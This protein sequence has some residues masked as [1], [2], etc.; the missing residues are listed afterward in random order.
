MTNP[1]A[2]S[3]EKH[4][5]QPNPADGERSAMSLGCVLSCVVTS[6]LLS[7]TLH[8]SSLTPLLSTPERKERSALLRQFDVEAP[9]LAGRT[10]PWGRPIT[11][12]WH[13]VLLAQILARGMDVLSPN[14]FAPVG[15]PARRALVICFPAMDRQSTPDSTSNR[16]I[17]AR[18]IR[19]RL[20]SLLTPERTPPSLR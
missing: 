6:D 12:R 15:S 5:S 13:R 19:E 11:A 17:R 7:L 1:R 4:R 10:P 16:L 14:R 9:V 20:A 8:L 18:M 2:R 3:F